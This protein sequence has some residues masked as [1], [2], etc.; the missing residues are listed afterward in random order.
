[1]INPSMCT[2]FSY[3]GHAH[4]ELIRFDK[5]AGLID[6]PFLS[7]LVTSASLLTA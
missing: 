3:H 2:V 6:D 5:L 1:M 4:L 7:L